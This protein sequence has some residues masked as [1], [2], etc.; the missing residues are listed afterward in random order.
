MRSHAAAVLIL[1]AL[2]PALPAGLV[3]AEDATPPARQEM[4]APIMQPEV[5]RSRIERTATRLGRPLAG[6][7][8]GRAT[9]RFVLAGDGRLRTLGLTASSGDSLIDAIA[10]AAVEEAAPFPPPDNGADQVYRIP[11]Q[12]SK[13]RQ[14]VTE[15]GRPPARGPLLWWWIDGQTGDVVTERRLPELAQIA[16]LSFASRGEEVVL[17][18]RLRRDDGGA[19]ALDG[20]GLPLL[21]LADGSTYLAAGYTE[22][23]DA[24]AFRITLQDGELFL[25]RLTAG[26]TRIELPATTGGGRP[27]RLLATAGAT[28][29]G[30]LLRLLMRRQEA[31]TAGRP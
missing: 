21:R 18:V 23:L 11:I 17:V 4:R 16:S 31:R 19:A 5:V 30:T 8:Q 1:L 28:G 13:T 9:V 6:E 25:V 20:I 12:L 24:G 27:R 26:S 15:P 29:P 3:Q 10:L 7:R 14:P 2:A 22:R